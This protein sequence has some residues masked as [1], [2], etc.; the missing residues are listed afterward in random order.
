[1]AIREK[2]KFVLSK[3]NEIQK[4][5]GIFIHDFVYPANHVYIETVI[6]LNIWFF[7]L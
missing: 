2:K 1:M 5:N 3:Q 4:K 7:F 6:R